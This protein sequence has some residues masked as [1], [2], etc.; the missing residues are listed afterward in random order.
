MSFDAQGQASFAST[1]LDDSY[2]LLFKDLKA[3][4]GVRLT[5][6]PADVKGALERAAS[7]HG[8]DYALLYAVAR[9]ESGF[10]TQAVSPK[11]AVGVMQLMPDTA[12][13]YG[14][15]G[16][17]A[18]TLKDNMHQLHGN[19]EAGSRYLSDLL[20]LFGGDVELAVAAYNAGEGAVQRS[21]NRIPNYAET[22]TYVERVMGTY[23]QM[24]GG[25]PAS[26]ASSLAAAA[27]PGLRD[28]APA[29]SREASEER[30]VAAPARGASR[31]G[32]AK[33]Q[34]YLGATQEIQRFEKGF[35]VLPSPALA[36]AGVSPA[37]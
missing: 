2:R 20:K 4:A 25:P 15:T 18:V 5:E 12:R 35:A 11:G 22:H 26:A 8:V 36:D 13:R 23:R 10:D 34:V 3:G 16:E 29:M 9:A 14:I 24:T 17:D 33:V 21:G 32:R 37:R 7:R 31:G 28:A 1:P 30:M 27:A 6:P 19:V